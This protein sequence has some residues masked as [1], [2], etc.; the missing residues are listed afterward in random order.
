[1]RVSKLFT[2]TSKTAP[3]DEVAKNAQ[4]LIRAGFIHKEMAGVY[5]YLPLGKIVLNKIIDIIREEMDAIGGNELSLTAL[6]QKD[7]WEASGR[8][9]D[10]VMDVWFKTK[11]ASGSELGLAPTHEEPLTKLMKSFISSY[12][13]LPVYPYQFQIKFRN[14]LRSKSGLMRGREFWMKDLYSFSRDQAEHDAFYELISEAYSRVYARL[15]LGE[16][17]Y[18]TFASGGSFAKY[19]HEFQTLSPVGEDKI[20]VHKGKHIAI[21]EEVYNDEVLADLGITKDELVE[22][23]AVEVGNI[24]TL[25]TKFSDAINLNFTDE[26]GVSK[27]V[28]MGSYGIGPSRVMGLIAE[29]FSD[30]KG[31]VWPENVAPAKV[32]L[33]RIGGDEAVAHADALYE[34]LLEKGIE[35]LYDDRDER[36]GNKFGDAELMGIPYRITVSDRLIEAGQYEFTPRTG[37]ETLLLTRDELL[38]KLN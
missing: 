33:V 16:L 19:S 4:L 22:E 8:W 5:D 32:Y 13:D 15:G 24:F 14:E 25:G 38:D 36:P 2:K 21:N 26:D 34:E 9:D 18:K 30:D 29:H 27:P 6:Q 37:G 11:L 31:L 20:Y 23:T 10:K 1:M 7:V 35:V 3:G 12:K 17:T 28:I